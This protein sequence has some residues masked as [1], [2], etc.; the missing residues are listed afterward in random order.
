MLPTTLRYSN[1]FYEELAT[2]AQKSSTVPCS[3]SHDMPRMELDDLKDLRRSQALDK[4]QETSPMFWTDNPGVSL[5][6]DCISGL[7]LR[8]WAKVFAKVGCLGKELEHCVTASLIVF[9]QSVCV[10]LGVL[11]KSALQGPCACHKIGTSRCTKC[12][13][14]HIAQ[15]CQGDSQQEHF[16][17]QHPDAKAQLSRDFLRFLKTSHMSNSHDSLH[18]PRNLY[19]D[20][21]PLRLLHLSRK[22]DSTKT[23][24]K[25]ITKAQNAHGTTTRAW[26]RRA[27]TPTHQILRA[28]AV[29]MHFEDLEGIQCI[30]MKRPDGFVAGAVFCGP[31]MCSDI[32]LHLYLRTLDL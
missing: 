26:S 17:R 15:P 8:L 14:R 10:T 18:L 30:V 9:F 29:E 32:S 12:C 5:F 28:C 4:R 24:G 1:V 2:D 25:V 31:C 22:V 21:K 7:S 6:C 19:I 23:R 20:I 13:A 27:P 3:K 16:Q 11:T